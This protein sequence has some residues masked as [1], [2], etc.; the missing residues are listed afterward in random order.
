MKG[1]ELLFGPSHLFGH[2]SNKSQK[3]LFVLLIDNTHFCANL[4]QYGL[5]QKTEITSRQIWLNAFQLS[6]FRIIHEPRRIGHRE[7]FPTRLPLGCPLERS[8]QK[9]DFDEKIW[10]TNINNETQNTISPALDPFGSCH[11]WLS[12]HCWLET[13][14]RIHLRSSLSSPDQRGKIECC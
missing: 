3:N 9:K 1:K 10:P 6:I 14:S 5:E 8:L 12:I 2:H 11:F 4:H 7:M 13:F